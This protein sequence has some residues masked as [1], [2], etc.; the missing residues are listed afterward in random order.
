VTSSRKREKDEKGKVEK[1]NTRLRN[2]LRELKEEKFAEHPIDGPGGDCVGG[3]ASPGKKKVGKLRESPQVSEGV[4]R[5]INTLKRRRWKCDGWGERNGTFAVLASWMHAGE[6]CL[7]RE[8]W[9]RIQKNPAVVM[10]ETRKVREE[11]GRGAESQIGVDGKKKKKRIAGRR[12][13]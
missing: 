7:S 2:R 13:L 4:T 9:R 10:S 11:G 12:P 6:P 1:L 8:R 5:V 3:G